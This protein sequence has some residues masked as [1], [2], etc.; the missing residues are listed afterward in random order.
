MDWNPTGVDWQGKTG[1][2]KFG[3][4]SRLLVFFYNRPV[5]QSVP[6]QQAGRPI[7]KDEIYIKIQQPGENLNVIDRPIKDEDKIRFRNMWDKFV[8]DRTQVP[9]G[10]P[11]DQLFPNYPAVAET[12]RGHGVYT[13]EQCANLTAHAIDT[14]GRG[15]QEYVNRARKYLDMSDKGAEFHVLQREN[16]GL[17]TEMRVLEAKLEKAIDQI[18]VLT[19]RLTDPIRGS[20]SPPYIPG[21][22]VQSERINANAVSSEVARRHKR[23]TLEDKI[24]DPLADLREEV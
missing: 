2:V 19:G 23:N 1:M 11:I 10:T 16:D 15:G 5:L 13:I 17:K 9:E 3:D 7:Y 18:K 22:D 4:D 12:L 24:T 14:I 20:M 8:H 21:H 6:S